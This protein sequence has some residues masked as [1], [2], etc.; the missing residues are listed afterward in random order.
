LQG[1]F[2]PCIQGNGNDIKWG[3]YPDTTPSCP[4]PTCGMN[5][6]KDFSTDHPDWVGIIESEA[7]KSFQAAYA[8]YAVQV[9]LAT[10]TPSCPLYVRCSASPTPDQNYTAFVLGD[11]PFPTAGQR[12]LGTTN[13]GVYYFYFMENAQIALGQPEIPSTGAGWIRYSPSYPPQDVGKFLSLLRA[14]GRA[15]GNAAAHEMGHHLELITNIKSNGNKGF[16]YMDCGLGNPGDRNRSTPIACENNDNFVYS[17]YTA[18]G[19]P[20]DP[21][22]PTSTG[23]MF[24]YGVPGGTPGIPSQAAIHWE[25]AGICWLQNFAVPGSCKQQ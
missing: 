1:Y 24:F 25:T 6:F 20:Q 19:F 22:D 11:Y 8:K 4:S 3:Y 16:P 23:G 17:F 21:S 12:F 9:Q 5:A 10:Q 15:I 18:D 2:G 14:I 7:F 13:S